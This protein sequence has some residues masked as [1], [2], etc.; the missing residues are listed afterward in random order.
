MPVVL[1][2]GKKLELSPGEHNEVQA[3][4]VH[5]FAPRFA[6]GSKVLYLR[7]TAQSFVPNVF[8]TASAFSVMA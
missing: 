8:M 7:D 1:S 5:E 2:D 3:A 4:V 6:P